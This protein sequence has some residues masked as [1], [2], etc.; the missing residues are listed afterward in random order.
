MRVEEFR[1]TVLKKKKQEKKADK[2]LGDVELH[3]SCK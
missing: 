1:L 2:V 3:W